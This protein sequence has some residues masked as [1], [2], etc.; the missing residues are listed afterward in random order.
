VAPGGAVSGPIIIRPAGPAGID[1]QLAA[2]MQQAGMD[3]TVTAHAEFDPPVVPLGE[4]VTYRVVV[5]AMIEG[6]SLPEKLPTPP[7]LELTLSGRGFSYESLGNRIQ[8]RTTHNYRVSVKSPG[9][10][11]LP[12]YRGSAEGKSV[13]IPE[14]RLQVLPAGTPAPGRSA[15][16]LVE[17]PAG[18]FY[19]GQ[20]LLVRVVLMDPGDNSV[21][22]LSQPHVSGDA[23][24]AEPGPVRYRRELRNDAG[25]MVAAHI[26]EMLVTPIKEGQLSLAAQGQAIFNRPV[27]GRGIALA[28]YNPLLDSEPVSVTVKHLPPEGEL[29]GFTGAIGSFRIELPRPSTN[30]VRAGE[31]LALTVTVRGEGN[32]TRLVPPKPTWAKGWQIFPPLADSAS[33]MEIQLRGSVSFTYALIPVS[34]TVQATPV[35]PFCCFDPTRQ[36]YVDL[37]IPPVPIKVLPAPNGAA[38]VATVM[39]SVA[40][41]PS[42]PPIER[43]LAMTGLA[44]SPGRSVATLMPVQERA[45]FFALQFAPA[46][47][48][49]GLWWWNQRRRYLA[50]HPEIILKARARRGL[51]RQLRLARRAVAARDAGRFATAAVN[52]LREACAPHA[53]ANP[54]ALV[55]ADVLTALPPDVQRG[56]G[57]QAVRALFAASD[58]SRFMDQPPDGATLLALQ[59]ELERLLGQLRERL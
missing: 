57:G 53:A 44:E 29:P 34:D 8:P 27:A 52:A 45:W 20:T 23:F 36:Q 54:Q 10:Y 6:V 55:C 16:L 28:N 15:R 2:A 12:S 43:E 18:E 19:I 26:C 13:T 22:G 1:P 56:N 32:L 37:T 41:D 24:V 51:Q 25:R 33:P 11:V 4:H 30:Q 7:G 14:A 48:L 3:L 9:A 42:Q 5:T 21:V 31:P 50:E 38:S 17:A 47:A 58:A 49:G 46:A 39:P 40:E 35:I 59:P